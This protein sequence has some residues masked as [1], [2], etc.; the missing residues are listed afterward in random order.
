MQQAAGYVAPQIARWQVLAARQRNCQPNCMLQHA[1]SAAAGTYMPPNQHSWSTQCGMTCRLAHTLSTSVLWS[2]CPP[3][4]LPAAAATSLVGHSIMQ[5][6]QLYADCCSHAAAAV[7]QGLQAVP[8]LLTAATASSPALPLAP[9]ALLSTLLHS[10]D[11]PL[12][13]CCCVQWTI[14]SPST[15]TPAALSG[16]CRSEGRSLLRGTLQRPAAAGAGA[17][18]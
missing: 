11:A 5:H 12:L 10:L 16:S 7:F 8:C 3:A 14:C 2:V 4:C 9:A 17:G 15:Q 18:C 13:P 6:T 1:A